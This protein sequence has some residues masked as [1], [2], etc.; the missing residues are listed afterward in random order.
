MNLFCKAQNVEITSTRYQDKNIIVWNEIENFCFIANSTHLPLSTLNRLCHQSFYTMI[1]HCG[2]NEIKNIRNIEIFK[3]EL[4]ST[5]HQMIDKLIEFSE[6]DIFDFN[7]CIV[8]SEVLNIN[9]KLQAFSDQLSL[10]Y[11]FLVKRNK[12]ICETDAFKCLNVD[13]K[14]LLNLMLTLNNNLLQKREI[15]IYLPLLSPF[16]AYR[17]INLTLIHDVTM[18]IIC[19]QSPSIAEI[20]ILSQK[21]W[22][23]SYDE[24]LFSEPSFSIEIDSIILGY[25]LVNQN[26]QKYLIS[27][28]LNQNKKQMHRMQILIAF[29][30]QFD[31]LVKCFGDDEA[32]M[33]KEL[34]YVSDYHK[35]HAMVRGENIFCVLFA[36]I[37][38]YA[39]K[40][41]SEDL[42]ASIQN[43]K[44]LVW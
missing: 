31:G 43:N 14:K 20:D 44:K 36:N 4:N 39:M 24:L 3:R 16:L 7:E 10:P 30:G 42:L 22:Q 9:S 2:L 17:L 32:V 19:G 1:M 6:N 40:F 13:E 26:K 27:N 12:I 8:G 5:F 25:L 29:F 15:P 33:T 38:T 35:C 37:P 41:C 28:Q 23:D 18:G 34:Y 11:C 21:F